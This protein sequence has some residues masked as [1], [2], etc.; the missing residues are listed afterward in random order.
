M[1]STTLTSLD[2]FQLSETINLMSDSDQS[3]IVGGTDHTLTEILAV[4]TNTSAGGLNPL[5]TNQYN[6]FVTYLTQLNSTAVGHTMLNQLVDATNISGKKIGLDYNS[7]LGTEWQFQLTSGGDYNLHFGFIGAPNGQTPTNPTPCWSGYNGA[8][9]FSFLSHELFHA[10]E[11][12]VAFYNDAVLLNAYLSSD[13]SEADAE[14]FSAM[15]IKQYDD[16]NYPYPYTMYGYLYQTRD[17][18]LYT[19]VWLNGAK[20]TQTSTANSA[21]AYTLDILVNV[22]DFSFQ[23]YNWYLQSFAAGSSYDENSLHYDSIS[24]LGNFDAISAFFLQAYFYGD[25]DPYNV[26]FGGG[27][28]AAG[29]GPN[30]NY[31]GTF[32]DFM[33]DVTRMQDQGWMFI[34]GGPTNVYQPGL[35]DM[36]LYPWENGTWS[37]TYQYATTADL[38]SFYV[39][40]NWSTQGWGFAGGGSSFNVFTSYTSH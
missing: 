20:T 1:K 27:S 16:I 17:A 11:Y 24:S 36:G 29:G 3:K 19:D 30:G 13:R 12:M 40:S 23:D 39:N 25:G 7:S 21:V 15:A 32:A 4:F 8:A 35:C 22:T 18:Q 5:T 14:L 28:G 31:F 34:V 10:Y 9:N 38:F 37:T 6:D 2:K 33:Y 26:G